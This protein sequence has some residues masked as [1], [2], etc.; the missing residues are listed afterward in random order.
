MAFDETCSARNRLRP[1]VG[2]RAGRH[3]RDGRNVLFSRGAVVSRRPAVCLGRRAWAVPQVG[4]ELVAV[5]SGV[6]RVAWGLGRGHMEIPGSATGLTSRPSAE[7]LSSKPSVG[8]SRTA[9]NI[10]ICR[11]ADVAGSHE[12]RWLVMRRRAQE[13][14]RLSR[15]WAAG[16]P[17]RHPS[18]SG[19]PAAAHCYCCGLWSVGIA[20]RRVVGYVGGRVP[21]CC[22]FELRIRVEPVVAAVGRWCPAHGAWRDPRAG[23]RGAIGLIPPDPNP[24]H[25]RK[26]G[27]VKQRYENDQCGQTP[28][29]LLSSLVPGTT[30]ARDVF[31]QLHRAIYLTAARP[32]PGRGRPCGSLCTLAGSRAAPVARA[33]YYLEVRAEEFAQARARRNGNDAVEGHRERYQR[34]S[35]RGYTTCGLRCTEGHFSMVILIAQ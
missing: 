13:D 12:A 4:Q 30:R 17:R 33:T 1:T 15:H 23:A 20:Q 2:I 19:L 31:V 21:A 24:D 27:D 29:H 26:C 9:A 10:L 16:L 5:P 32:R 7:M 18:G 11:I 14:Q 35:G 34:L 25:D 3:E 28:G 22:R 6:V 8:V